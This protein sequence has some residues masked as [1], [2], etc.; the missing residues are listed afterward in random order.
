MKRKNT[1]ILIASILAL[2]SGSAVAAENNALAAEETDLTGKTNPGETNAPTVLEG[3]IET[4]V[5]E[6]DVQDAGPYK[7]EVADG[8]SIRDNDRNKSIKIEACYPRSEGRFPVIV[9]SHGAVASAR[10]Y[11]PLAAFWASHGYVCVLPT[12]D[13]AVSQN[14][15]RANKVNAFKLMK[16]ASVDDKSINERQDD[17]E[18]TIDNLGNIENRVPNLVG[19]MDLNRLALVGHHAGAY[20]AEV[21]GGATIS[22]CNREKYADPRVKAIIAITG[23]TWHQPQLRASDLDSVKVPMMLISASPDGRDL[24]DARRKIADAIS[25]A[26]GGNKYFVTVDPLHQFGQ[27]IPAVMVARAIKNSNIELIPHPFRRLR[28]LANSDNNPAKN[29]TEGTIRISQVDSAELPGEDVLRH[30]GLLGILPRNEKNSGRVNF[31]MSVTLPFL[32]GYLKNDAESLQ[33]L[34]AMDQQKFDD[35]IVLK[36]DQY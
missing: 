9:F 5:V 23:K 13:D 3:N 15:N 2:T 12:H 33:E 16:I 35:R 14:M 19:K 28:N 31:V 29:N 7:V 24:S 10:D 22:K 25:N 1:I 32:D 36:I 21:T 34:K 18:R 4:K 27:Y 11:R 26:P 6:M 17:I 30:L 8:L 20:T